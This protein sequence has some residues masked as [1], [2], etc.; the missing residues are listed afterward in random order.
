MGILKESGDIK[1][2]DEVK[3]TVEL[4]GHMIKS[5]RQVETLRH[6]G[7][8]EKSKQEEIRFHRLEIKVDDAFKTISQADQE[9]IVDLL[10]VDKMAPDELLDIVKTFKGRLANHPKKTKAWGKGHI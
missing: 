4:Y 6:M 3:E 1:I 5:M 8:V 10:V 2:S 9:N 7:E